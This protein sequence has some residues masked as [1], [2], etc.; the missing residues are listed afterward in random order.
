MDGGA[1]GSALG[2][3]P[4]LKG[5]RARMQDIVDVGTGKSRG[6]GHVKREIDGRVDSSRRSHGRRAMRSTEG[7]RS[8]VGMRSRHAKSGRHTLPAMTGLAREIGNLV[9]D[10]GRSSL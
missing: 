6:E 10:K 7:V 3:G 2:E 8:H 1:F 9:H 5:A 4:T